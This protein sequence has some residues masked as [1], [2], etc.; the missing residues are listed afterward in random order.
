MVGSGK[1]LPVS[2]GPIFWI[3]TCRSDVMR[4][5]PFG[6]RI[7]EV[8]LQGDH[9]FAGS[10]DVADFLGLL[11]LHRG[12]AFGEPRSARIRALQNQLSA[13]IYIAEP[14]LCSNGE[15]GLGGLVIASGC[16]V[17]L[18]WRTGT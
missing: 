11:H 2:I 9:Q 8:E 6:K 4:G 1:G 3:D 5:V 17:V 18:P 12:Q 13:A 15:E 16:S 14:P 7:A 10:V